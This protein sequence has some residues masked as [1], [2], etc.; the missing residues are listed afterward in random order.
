MANHRD[1]P[2]NIAA[3]YQESGRA[4]RDGKLSYCRIYY[5]RQEVKSINFILNSSLQKD[6]ENTKAKRSVKEFD[7][8]VNHCESVRCRHLLFSQYFG[9]ATPDCKKRNLCDVCKDPK[10]A[11]KNLNEFHGLNLNGFVSKM[12]YDFN[13]T[14]DLYE[15]GRNSMQDNAASYYQDDDSESVG[16]STSARDKKA[17]KDASNLI[18]KEFERRR[19]KIEVAKQLEAT[20][21]RSAGIRVK[22]SI[23]TSKI[24]G[25]DVKKRESYLE[26]LVKILRENVE[27]AS[28]KPIHNLKA[29]DFEDI[30]VELEYKCFTN[31]RTVMMYTKAFTNERIRIDKCTKSNSLLPEIKNHTPKKRTAHGGSVE[32]MQ[33]ELDT[34]MKKNNIENETSVKQQ[35]ISPITQKNGE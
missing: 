33:M 31:N 32:V 7:K 24:A 35:N 17:A 4:G 3:Y 30:G 27:K 29:C 13:D 26:F 28:E 19:Q 22:S 5:C 16:S 21:T 9:D 6:P 34:F 18:Q 11:E 23:H 12:D 25:L 8:L 15:G 20:Q 10:Q 1:V 2:Q 14:S